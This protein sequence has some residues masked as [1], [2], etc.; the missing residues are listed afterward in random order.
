MILTLI[1]MI[2]AGAADDPAAILAKIHAEVRELGARPGEDF[3]RQEFFIGSAD[4]DDINKETSVVI[5]IQTLEGRERMTIQVTRMERD[6][7]DRRIKTALD[8]QI[9]KA[10]LDPGNVRILHSDY[11][12]K[13]LESVCAQTLRAVLGKKKLLRRGAVIKSPVEA[14]PPG[15]IEWTGPI[16][17]PMSIP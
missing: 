13:E 6:R 12:A 15:L 8:T 7:H 5:L 9:I 4:E 16:P 1:W 17:L 11:S 3:I 14:C 10:G 2:L